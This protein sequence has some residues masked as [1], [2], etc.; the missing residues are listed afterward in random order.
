MVEQRISDLTAFDRFFRR[1][2]IVDNESCWVWSGEKSTSGYGRFHAGRGDHEVAHRWLYR[3]LVGPIRDGLQLDHLCRVRLCVR[4]DHLEPVT[5]QENVRRSD[6][7]INMRMR[8]HCPK[9]HSYDAV[10]TRIVKARYGFGRQCR[11]CCR[12][13]GRISD[14]GRRLRR[15]M[16]IA[17]VSA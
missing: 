10:N 7:G 14:A 6:A 16:K 12:I 5:P 3:R 15:K 1:V 9:G 8:T 13:N 2:T 17:E 4:P 11:E